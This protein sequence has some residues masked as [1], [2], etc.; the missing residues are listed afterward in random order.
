[1]LSSLAEQSGKSAQAIGAFT[2]P[3]VHHC[4]NIKIGIGMFNLQRNVLAERFGSA[5]LPAVNPPIKGFNA[6]SL[7]SFCNINEISEIRDVF[8][9][10]ADRASLIRGVAFCAF[11]RKNAPAFNFSQQN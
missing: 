2:V 4:A 3:K 11:L 7:D 8:S 5:A 10:F 6:P 9:A 1:M